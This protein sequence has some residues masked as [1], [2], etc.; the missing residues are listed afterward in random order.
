[1]HSSPFILHASLPSPPQ[2]CRLLRSP[3]VS[4]PQVPPEVEELRGSTQLSHRIPCQAAPF[5]LSKVPSECPRVTHWVQEKPQKSHSVSKG[6][7]FVRKHYLVRAQQ[8]KRRRSPP[9]LPDVPQRGDPAPGSA[10][11]AQGPSRRLGL[12]SRGAIVAERPCR[13]GT[14]RPL[15]ARRSGFG[16]SALHRIKHCHRIPATLNLGAGRACAKRQPP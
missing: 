10:R 8:E 7:G 3:C 1:M 15:G 16:V 12:P 13:W 4:F 6:T 14:N 2:P 9:D 11:P 5:L